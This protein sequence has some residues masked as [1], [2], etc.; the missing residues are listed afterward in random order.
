MKLNL[1]MFF[2]FFKH[3]WKIFHSIHL[4]L[5][6][7][8]DTNTN[9]YL[10]SQIFFKTPNE[11]IKFHEN[12]MKKY[13]PT[14]CRPEIQIIFPQCLPWCQPTEP[15]NYANSYEIESFGKN[16]RRQKCWDKSMIPDD[17]L[18]KNLSSSTTVFPCQNPFKTSYKTQHNVDKSV[19]KNLTLAISDKIFTMVKPNLPSRKTFNHLWSYDL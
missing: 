15:L 8:L 11:T 12:S 4:F 1:F 6:F 19:V 13:F 3:P 9:M 16:G 17:Y 2:L 7:G 5:F 18:M 14:I 10:S